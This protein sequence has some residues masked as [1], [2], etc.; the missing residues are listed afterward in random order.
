VVVAFL[1]LAAISIVLTLIDLDTKR[2][3]NSIV[4]PSYLVGG[5]L[6]T[7]AS[8]LTGDWQ[9]LLR[10]GIGMVAL[11]TFYFLLRLVRPGGM[12]GGDV[13]LAGVL[14]LYL[15]WVGWGALAVG[16]FAAFLIGGIWGIG[17]IIAGRAGRKTAIPF[18]PWMILGA[19]VG[20]FAGNAVGRWYVNL[21]VGV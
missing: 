9:A 20:V 8:W 21:F 5:L 2:L 17:L 11:Y 1:Y 12:G 13:K 7:V 14:G 4:L 3:P 6:L 15:G 16:A 18:G 10:A 19:W